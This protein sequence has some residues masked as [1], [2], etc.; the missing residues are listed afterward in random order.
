LEPV[1]LYYFTYKYFVL[2]A[3]SKEI[4]LA[5]ACVETVWM[6]RECERFKKRTRKKAPTT[7]NKHRF[8]PVRPSKKKQAIC[9]VDWDDGRAEIPRHD[10]V[11]LAVIGLDLLKNILCGG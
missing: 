8:L 5:R 11:G 10:S 6:Q 3:S 7:L 1:F 2:C 4:A 9:L